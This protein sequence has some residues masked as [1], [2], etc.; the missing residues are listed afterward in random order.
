MQLTN[1]G[2]PVGTNKAAIGLWNSNTEETFTY[3]SSSD[4]WGTT[5]TPADINNANFGVYFKARDSGLNFA[6]ASVDFISVKVYYTPA[7]SSIARKNCEE[8]KSGQRML[9]YG[10]ICENDDNSG[11]QSGISM[12]LNIRNSSA[13]N[14]SQ[15]Y[16]AAISDVTIQGI[17]LRITCEGFSLGGRSGTASAGLGTSIYRKIKNPFQKRKPLDGI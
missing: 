3:G 7:G 1:N 9:F 12:T 8:M 15:N 14:Y 13:G 16:Q 5:W 11:G 2:S 17:I 10:I 6:V 4:L